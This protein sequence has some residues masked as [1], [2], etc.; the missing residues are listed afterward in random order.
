MPRPRRAIRLAPSLLSADFGALGAAVEA[1]EKGGADAFHLDVMD[2]H[3]V[4][5]LS[6]GPA[7]V[8][9]VRERTTLP[10]DI[11]LMI[12]DPEKY[13]PVFREAGGDT[14][15]VHVESDVSMGRAIEAGHALGAQVGAALRP[16]TPIDRVLPW[17]DRLDQVL[18]MSVHPG[19]SGQKF[20]PDILPKMAEVDRRLDEIGSSADISADGGITA[21][22]APEVVRAGAT[23]LVC[24]NS[25]FAGGDV[26]ANLASLRR[27]LE[28]ATHRAVR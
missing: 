15:V 10:L 5:N 23:F 8:R 24:G 20:L 12:Q 28:E 25:A 7:L 22:T 11:H 14:L 13:L 1:A 9:A 17:I 3:F 16:D 26:G 27:A 6:F 18:V 19:F 4:P 2:G 21:T